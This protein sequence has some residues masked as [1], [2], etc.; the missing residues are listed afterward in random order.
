MHHKV[1]YSLVF[2]LLIFTS[3][4]GQLTG[5]F[6]YSLGLPQQS[7]AKN[8]NTIHQGVLSVGYRLPAYLKFVQVGADLGYGG[9]A[10]LTVPTEF[11]FGNGRPTKTNINY[12]SNSFVA[13]GFVQFDLYRKGT[14]VPYVVLKG[15][16][17]NL[18]SSI[19]IDDP[20][21]IDGCRP[22]ENESIIAD[23]TAIFNYG[24]GIRYDLGIPN[25]VRRINRHYI[26]VQFMKTSGGTLDYINAKKLTDHSVHTSTP[27]ESEESRPLEMKFINVTSNVAHTHKV[28]EIFSTPLRLMD[29]RIGYYVEF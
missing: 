6:H 5:S 11:S 19:Y 29:I 17:Q 4:F 15:G 1:F 10:R 9:Y 3:T 21:D 8:I 2:S 20:T 13:N 25:Y 27:V 18:H 14:F 12:S 28:G 26:D 22:L 24:G 23:Q 7:M 16:V